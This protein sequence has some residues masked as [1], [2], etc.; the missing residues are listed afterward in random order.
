M[1]LGDDRRVREES[2]ELERKLAESE[3]GL[4]DETI[5]RLRDTVERMRAQMD[6]MRKEM[7]KERI[8]RAIQEEA[9]KVLW[10]AMRARSGGPGSDQR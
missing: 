6:S 2:D 9:I 1:F 3:A 10:E 5:Q 7:N 8:E 4:R